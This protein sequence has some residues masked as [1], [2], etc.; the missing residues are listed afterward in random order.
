VT[1]TARSYP[2]FFSGIGVAFLLELPALH[3]V[4]VRKP[5]SLENYLAGF[6]S[7]DLVTL[8]DREI[9]MLQD[10][11]LQLLTEA[12]TASPDNANFIFTVGPETHLQPGFR[13]NV[14]ANHARNR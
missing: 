6:S 11:A 2:R 8:T 3:R 13:S 7:K 14:T 9:S 12:K 1:W 5:L 10:V 4:R